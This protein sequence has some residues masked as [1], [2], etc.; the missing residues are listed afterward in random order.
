VVYTRPRWEKKVGALLDKEAI[1]NFCPV[2]KV[3]RQ[4]SDRRKTIYEPLFSS[5]V[6]VRI[7][8]GDRCV[9]QQTEGFLRFIQRE[10]RPVTIQP[11]EIRELRLFM[12]QHQSLQVD[13]IAVDPNDRVRILRGMTMARQGTD[14]MVTYHSVKLI[15]PTLGYVV[16]ATLLLEDASAETLS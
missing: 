13:H 16:T 11:D 6:F 12:Q 4:W 7:A 8:P 15:L 9:V 3:I 1:E 2:N 5:M 14:P 10:G